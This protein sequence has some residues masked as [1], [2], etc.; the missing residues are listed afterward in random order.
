[1]TVH[2]RYS[3]ALWVYLYRSQTVK[4][5]RAFGVIELNVDAEHLTALVSTLDL[6]N[7]EKH[8]TPTRCICDFSSI[9]RIYVC[10]MWECDAAH[11]LTSAG[12]VQPKLCLCVQ[13]CSAVDSPAL[14]AVLY[15]CTDGNAV[16]LCMVLILMLTHSP[17]KSL[18]LGSYVF[19]MCFLNLHQKIIN[20]LTRN[21]FYF[22]ALIKPAFTFIFLLYNV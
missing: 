6:K 22:Y 21:R 5:R 2:K 14:C 3:L 11:Y 17:L 16:F 20:Y 19:K 7:T 18:I 15:I 4:R 13:L 10:V 1:M 12:R 8:C 9:A